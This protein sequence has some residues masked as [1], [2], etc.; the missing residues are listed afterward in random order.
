MPVA[1]IGLLVLAVVLS[2][3]AVGLSGDAQAGS[4]MGSGFCVLAALLMFV[5][6]RL[7][8]DSQ[9]NSATDLHQLSLMSLRR[10][11]L[12][13]TLTIGL[14]AVASF[15]IVAVS[16]FRLTPTEQ[17]TAGFDYV[18]QSSQPIFADLGSTDGQNEMLGES[19]ADTT[20][21]F[22]FRF[23]PG[24]DAS[25]NNLYQSTQPRVL[26]ASQRF[27]DS[28]AADS[29]KFAW[30]GSIAETDSESA[31]PW[32]L[33]NRSYD[34]GAIPVIID[35][36]T[37]NYSLKIFAPGGDYVVNFDSGETVTFRVVGFLSNT[38]LQGSLLVSEENFIRA[39]PYLGG[40]RYFLIDSGDGEDAS[41][42]VVSVLENQLG[43]E[44]FDAQSAP[45]LLENF[46]SVQNTYLST[47]QSLGA[48]GLLLGTFGLA[49]VQIRSVLERKR[50]LGLMRAVG[51]GKTRLAKMILIENIW[52]LGAGLVIGVLA[53]LCGTLPHY[54][55]GAASVPWFALAGIF[56]AIFVI[57]LF[58]SYLATR[59]LS[60][61]NLLESLRA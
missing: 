19:L 39:F 1:I 43:D 38:I 50:E 21:I 60:R 26:G 24:E 28:F 45:R 49:A 58:A 54:L 35:K 33:L 8:N 48:L 44:G 51:F 9:V 55:F 20:R 56:L 2:V 31:N 11:P 59:V 29:T 3:V 6:S 57:G 5:F 30:G 46:M 37:A 10:N 47:F 40:S 32:T 15:L 34:D 52:L 53:A 18:A 23:K 61:M 27:I 22:G 42:K 25:C 12:R 13:S 16:S 14:V 7:K 17:G 41:G 4:F 36:N